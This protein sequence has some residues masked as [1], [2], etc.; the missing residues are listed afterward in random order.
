MNTKQATQIANNCIIILKPTSTP[1]PIVA[2][3]QQTKTTTNGVSS[4][5]KQIKE[6]I[7]LK[8]TNG[9][10]PTNGRGITKSPSTSSSSSSWSSS[11]EEPHQFVKTKPPQ[12]LNIC[13]SIIMNGQVVATSVNTNVVDKRL[14]Q[15]NPPVE[16]ESELDRV[17]RVFFFYKLS[18][19]LTRFG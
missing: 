3:P 10:S 7:V 12:A 1:Q 2:K 19:I 16:P 4:N 9:L 13:P 5:L 11:S 17:F 14:R 6:A 15:F 8:S 18:L